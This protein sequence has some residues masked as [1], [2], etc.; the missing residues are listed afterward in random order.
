MSLAK[1]LTLL[2]I[3]LAAAACTACLGQTA[4][5]EEIIKDARS[6][7]KEEKPVEAKAKAEEAAKLDSRRYESY[8][9]LALIAIQQNDSAAAKAALDKA[10]ELAPA[11]K[12]ASLESL[13]D[14]L[15][16]SPSQGAA[17]STASPQAL[18]P[19]LPPDARRKLD[20][21]M[22]IVEDADKAGSPEDRAKYLAEY[23]AKSE[24]FLRD[25][26]DTIP[27]W[28][29]RASV[30]LELRRLKVAWESGR[31][32][33]ALGADKRDDAAAR[34]LFAQL[35][36]K[37]LMTDQMPSF[38]PTPGAKWENE[39][40][41]AFVPINGTGVHILSRPVKVSEFLLFLREN[42]SMCEAYSFQVKQQNN[43]AL[44]AR[45]ADRNPES[46]AFASYSAAVTF[47]KWLT[48]RDTKANLIQSVRYRLPQ[49]KEFQ[50]AELDRYVSDTVSLI[51]G[52][53]SP[54]EIMGFRNPQTKS[55][56]PGT[57]P[58]S[59][60]V[61]TGDK[62]W[63]DLGPNQMDYRSDKP[64][65]GCAFFI[66][67]AP[68]T[69]DGNGTDSSSEANAGYRAGVARIEKAS[70]AKDWIDA[71]AT[72]QKAAE[73]GNAD[74]AE[75]LGMIYFFGFGV[76]QD[77]AEAVKWYR[78]AAEQ[79]QVNGQ[80]HLGWMY[81][82]GRGVPKN[83]GE[84]VKWYTKATEQGHNMAKSALQEIRSE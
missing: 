56:S 84:A 4:K 53:L 45:N 78:N 40:G 38:Q 49:R 33:V 19:S 12:R 20:V 26:P 39:L 13:R 51:S 31:K 22:L 36:R 24:E 68:N 58:P 74:A 57:A 48:E 15:P 64:Q 70:S 47:C 63:M 59:P 80:Y 11:E 79:G 3:I 8:A 55:V 69:S 16:A 27:V 37:G 25:Y 23:L 54:L 41:M 6:L 21:L 14:K 5:Y 67:L 17:Q 2:P 1:H 75:N 76:R 61:R 34:K 7:L 10:L 35:E 46:P 77:D 72:F 60:Y 28:M 66:V 43:E 18:Q 82:R 42:N 9:V 29:T 32:L 52:D 73:L 30:A 83:L 71:A 65:A 50:L 62:T 81:Q 44:L